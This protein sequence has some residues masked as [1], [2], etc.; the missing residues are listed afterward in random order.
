MRLEQWFVVLIL[1]ASCAAP[2]QQ[3]DY[4]DAGGAA[5]AQHPG[6]I[7][8]SKPPYSAK[9]D[10]LT[11]DTAAI[12]QALDDTGAAGGGIVFVP[13]GRYRIATHLSIPVATTLKGVFEGPPVIVEHHAL[14]MTTGWGSM[15]MAEEN[16]GNESGTPFITL[17]GHSAGIDGFL[18]YYPNQT[19]TNPPVPYPWTVS[20]GQDPKTVLHS[21]DVT[22]QNITFANAYDGLDLGSHDSSRHV[23][24]GIYGQVLHRGIWVDQCYNFGEIHDVHFDVFWADDQPLLDFTYQQGIAYLFDRSDGEIMSDVNAW[25]FHVGMQFERPPTRND[26]GSYAFITNLGLETCDVGVMAIDTVPSGVSITNY[27]YA[28]PPNVGMY[29][30]AIWGPA[31]GSMYGGVVSVQNASIVAAYHQ[32]VRWEQPGGT[33]QL[34]GS[35]LEPTTDTSAPLVDIQAGEAIISGNLF[36][37]GLAAYPAIH[38]A[39]GPSIVTSNVVGQGTITV[40]PTTTR[41]T[42]ANNQ[43]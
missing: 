23:V 8:V 34:T 14:P 24:R 13:T 2:A 29:R 40:D 21:L 20:V 15:L 22:I 17:A 31:A 38:V 19:A 1:T 43:N 27:D 36:P 16:A 12:Q 4:D 11:D 10:G 6:W 18:I 32:A 28:T 42:V 26:F 3:P 35:R 41:V 37:L 39:S 7:D 30:Y 5:P 9:G 33:V 25:G